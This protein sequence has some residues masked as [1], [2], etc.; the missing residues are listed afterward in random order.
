MTIRWLTSR[1]TSPNMSRLPFLRL[2]DPSHRQAEY[3][4]LR[5][6]QLR[7][8]T[9]RGLHTSSCLTIC[10][11]Y[12]CTGMAEQ[13]K[14]RSETSFVTLDTRRSGPPAGT[15]GKGTR[16]GEGQSRFGNSPMVHRSVYIWALLRYMMLLGMSLIW[17]SCL[18]K[19]DRRKRGCSAVEVILVT[20]K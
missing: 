17:S 1:H 2:Y 19:S 11:V 10:C 9:T 20:G 15:D 7:P 8:G 6:I 12:P 3:S 14:P 16:N 18:P 4:Y 13:A 5:R